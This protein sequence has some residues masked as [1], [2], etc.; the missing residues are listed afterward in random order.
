VAA[1][2][3]LATYNAKRD[4]KRTPEPFDEGSTGHAGLLFVIHAHNARRMHFDLRLEHEG[5]LVSWAVPKGLPETTKDKH[6]AVHVED[7]PLSYA[8]FEGFIPKGE[9]GGGDVIIW[10]KGRYVPLADLS[11]S[12]KDGKLVFELFGQ[13]ARGL[14]TLVR[15]KR[16]GT[17]GNQWLLMKKNDDWQPKANA[18]DVRPSQAIASELLT[19]HVVKREVE[20]N[21]VQLMLAETAERAFS[22]PAFLFEL[23]YDGYRLLASK[24]AGVPA[25]RYRN[26]KIVN[27]KYPEITA[28]I[29]ALDAANVILDGELVALDAEGVPRFHQLEQRAQLSQPRDIQRGMGEVPLVYMAFDLLALEGHDLRALPLIE[30]KEYLK[31]LLARASASLRFA[32]HVV[33][34]GEALLEH[35]KRMNGLEGIMAKRADGVYR[36]GRHPDWKK[37]RLEKTADLVVVGFS[38]AE[39]SRTGF[40]A[41]L[42]ASRDDEGWCY[43]GRVGT[44]FDTAQLSSIHKRLSSLVR[45]NAACE[46]PDPKDRKD[47]TWV[48]PSLVVEVRFLQLS[49]EGRLRLPVFLRVRDDKAAQ[50]CRF[51]ARQEEAPK[52]LSVEAPLVTVSNPSKAF[53][54]GVSKAEL[55]AYYRSVAPYALPYYQDRPALLTRFPDGYDGKSFFQKDAPDFAP[56]WLRRERMFSDSTNRDIDH[57]VLDTAEALA[58]VAN[59]GTIPIHVWS[60]RIGSLDRPDYTV[61]DLDP[62]QAPFS[63]V[64]TIALEVR[65]LCAAIG[66]PAFVKTTGSSGLHILI[67][68]GGV[69]TYAQSKTLAMLIGGRVVD[70]LPKLAT[71]EREPSRRGG[72]V[73]LDCIQNGHGKT[74]AGPYCVRPTQEASVSMP[75][76]WDAVTEKLG[77]RDFT[78]KNAL[79]WLAARVRDPHEGLLSLQPDLVRALEQLARFV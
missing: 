64:V 56:A 76:E 40:G 21:D 46:V 58:Y 35:V 8:E 79:P 60:S 19:R 68:L 28:A 51:E 63:D 10:D 54:P 47:V 71:M 73:Y 6:L 20:V 43:R 14:F 22:D 67:P 9:Y 15:T 24:R 45:A 50:A 2:K 72:K 3:K 36:S 57:F 5:V 27:D 49:Q 42:L 4:P 75:I 48:E 1:K 59:M 65:A 77:P 62:K 23:K 16:G 25:L 74:I 66:L 34:H 30:R 31:R 7:H 12:L 41:L 26:G 61:I 17:K 32:D 44:G 52:N 69:C 55:V 37:L 70:R 38:K 78:I 29:Q 18:K 53:F 33:E 39:G 11:Q 13:R